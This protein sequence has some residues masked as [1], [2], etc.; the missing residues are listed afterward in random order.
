MRSLPSQYGRVHPG[1]GVQPEESADHP[2]VGSVDIGAAAV[3]AQSEKGPPDGAP[4]PEPTGAE[5]VHLP[6]GGRVSGVSIS[7]YYIYL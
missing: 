5:G 2:P 1:Q 3:R 7:A 4:D 6:G